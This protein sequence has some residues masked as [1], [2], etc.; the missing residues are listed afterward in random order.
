MTMNRRHFL[1]CVSLLAVLPLS[2]TASAELPMLPMVQRKYIGPNAVE[3]S[4]SGSRKNQLLHL[5]SMENALWIKSVTW[6]D[7][8]GFRHVVPIRKNLPPGKNMPL[9]MIRNARSICLAITCLPLAS[10]TTRVELHDGV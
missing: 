8:E 6:E 3:V 5:R 9:P 4:F 7:Q 10:A 1:S 2:G